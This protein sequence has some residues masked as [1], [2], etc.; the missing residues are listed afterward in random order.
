MTNKVVG[1][2]LVV[3]WSESEV[4]GQVVVGFWLGL[5]KM[6]RGWLLLGSA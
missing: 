3:R 2:G 5:V 6:V 4:V 1:M